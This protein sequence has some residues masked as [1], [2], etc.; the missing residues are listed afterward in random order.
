VNKV[1]V[2]YEGIVSCL[3]DFSV[4]PAEKTIITYMVLTLSAIFLAYAAGAFALPPQA[5]LVPITVLAA[6]LPVLPG[7]QGFAMWVS[8]NFKY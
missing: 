3:L 1:S 2:K 4:F 8:F 5:D 7:P 6:T